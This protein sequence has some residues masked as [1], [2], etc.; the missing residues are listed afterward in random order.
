MYIYF[1]DVLLIESTSGMSLP[2][3]KS[4]QACSI[5]NS[6]QTRLDL[7]PSDQLIV[8]M[9]RTC[10]DSKDVR[11]WL[12]DV[13][14]TAENGRVTYADVTK[15]GELM[16]T[17]FKTSGK[18]K[19]PSFTVKDYR[20]MDFK[21]GDVLPKLFRLSVGGKLD[22]VLYYTNHGHGLKEIRLL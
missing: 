6:E 9:R 19:Y 16:T 14:F 1:L 8:F 7:R 13:N 5:M 17:L 12:R 20:A 21:F 18:G 4:L 2:P 3:L 22:P 11:D 10:P 15:G